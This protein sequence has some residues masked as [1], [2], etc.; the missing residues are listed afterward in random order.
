M[1]WKILIKV[2]KWL[3]QTFSLGLMQYYKE[4]K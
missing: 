1:F 4:K 2:I 3:L